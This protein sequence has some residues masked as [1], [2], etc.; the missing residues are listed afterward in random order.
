MLKK[1]EIIRLEISGMTNEGNGVGKH[2]GI[3]VFVP[4]TVI[5]DVIECRIVKVCKT[6]CYGIIEN[7]VSGSVERTKNDCPVYSRCGGCC[8]RHMSYEEECRVKEQFIKDSF[9]RIGK[10]YPEYDSFEGCKQLVGYRNKAQYPVAEQDGRAVC[11]FYSRRS[12]HVCDHTDCALQ[13][14]IFKAIADE[15]MAYVN[16]RKIKAYNEETGSCL[17]RHIYLRRGEHSGEIMVCLVITD[18]K[19]RGVFDALVG[20]LCKKYADIKSIVFN[21]NSRKTNCIL[22]QKLVTA[23]GSNTIHDTMCGNDIEISPLSFYQVNTIQAER[24]YEIAAD[25]AQLTGKETLLDLYCGAGTIGLSMSKKVKKLIGVEIIESAIDNAKRNAAANNVTNAEFICGDAGKIAEILYSRGERPDVIIAD[26]ARKGCTRDALEYM[27][28]MSPDRIVMIS[29]NHATAARDCAVLE[30]LEYKTVKVKGVDLFG[31]TGHVETVVLLSHRSPDSV[32]NVKVEFGEGDDKISL[33]AIVELAKKYNVKLEVLSSFTGHPGTKVKGVAKRME[34]TAVSSVAKDKDI[35]RIALVGVP[36][37]VGTSFKVFSL[38]AQNHINVDIILQ[39]IGHE[40]GKDICFT[41]AEG[42]LK[43]AAELLESHKAELRF[44]RLETNADIAKVSV[45]GSG[46]IN[47]PGV[48]AKLFEALYDAHININMISTSE[49]KISVLV[50]KKDAD[51]AVQAV[52]D[53][54]FAF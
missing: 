19:K 15:I 35:A 41:V 6:Y 5:G 26:P 7:I 39:G 46:M 9:E 32:I 18:L 48:A 45:V 38:L 3:A 13:P 23:Y 14:A 21:E 11:G 34:K 33:D 4:F 40:E 16:K 28:K 53:K 31:R 27:A 37:E 20:E 22:G 36:N 49:I 30:E 51:R 52:H 24:L 44:A 54:F 8:F 43:K 47:N 29:C 17:L 10:L 25:Y 42:D 50:D 12:H 2:E 1:N